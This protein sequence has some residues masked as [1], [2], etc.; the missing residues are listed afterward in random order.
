MLRVAYE[1]VA[2]VGIDGDIDTLVELSTI[3]TR[4]SPDKNMR[5]RSLLVL[6]IS[7]ALYSDLAAYGAEA[8]PNARSEQEG[9]APSNKSSAKVLRVGPGKDFEQ[10]L[11]GQQHG[12][13]RQ[14]PG[15]AL[16]VRG[17]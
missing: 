1:I 16:C 4:W 9:A 7:I 2:A 12:S 13:K 10:A 14:A 5:L 17:G 6:A 3:D 11:S 8:A 15:R